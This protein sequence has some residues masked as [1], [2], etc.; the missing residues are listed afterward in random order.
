M[1]QHAKRSYIFTVSHSRDA[2]PGGAQARGTDPAGSA[3]DHD[4]TASDVRV[5]LSAIL[6]ASSHMRMVFFENQFTP[7]PTR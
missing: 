1:R 5:L 2:G 4:V 6:Q 7:P 3:R